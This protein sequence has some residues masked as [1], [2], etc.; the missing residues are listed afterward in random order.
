MNLTN[1]KIGTR[2]TASFGLLV[3]VLL[4]IVLSAWASMAGMHAAT[5]DLAGNWMPSIVQTGNMNNYAEDTRILEFQH[6]LNTD[7]AKMGAIEKELTV[8]LAAFDNAHQAY[9]PMISSQEEQKLHDAMLAD[10][11]QYL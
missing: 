8:T 1:L 5:R 4:G 2:M 11:K 7:D 6:V 10:W 3:A 9:V